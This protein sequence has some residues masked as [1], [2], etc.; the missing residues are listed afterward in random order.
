MADD[1][2]TNA[3]TTTEE[4]EPPVENDVE[5][6]TETET[7]EG[8]EQTTEEKSAE[9]SDAAAVKEIADLKARFE[10]LAK[11]NDQLTSE[12]KRARRRNE[13][14]DSETAEELKEAQRKLD[15]I[16]LERER[17]EAEKSRNYE[18]M[19]ELAQQRHNE[20]MAQILEERDRYKADV[21]NRIKR[22]LQPELMKGGCV[23]ELAPAAYAFLAPRIELIGIGAD[24]R[25][26]IDGLDFQE[27]TRNWLSSDEGRAFM[28]VQITAGGGATGGR[29]RRN[30]DAEIEVH[31]KPET[32]N[33]TEVT[34]VYRED[35][36]AYK[37]M[38]AKYP[39]PGPDLTTGTIRR[40]S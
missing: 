30:P 17:E 27:F 40:V 13:K 11:N 10:R 29:Q 33:L 9:T 34:R 32:Y 8:G 28:P 1:A 24:R 38:I 16:A 6:K 25:G 3:T 36:E 19:Q 20:E 18:R 5:T 31:F 14:E 21:E 23:H 37:R 35:P 12:L 15:Q 2:A 39:T 22:E 4:A 7:E 26:V